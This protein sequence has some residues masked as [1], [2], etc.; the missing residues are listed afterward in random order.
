MGPRSTIE[1]IRNPSLIMRVAL[2]LLV[3]MISVGM[4]MAA[5][6]QTLRG[7][8]FTTSTNDHTVEWNENWNA[9][10]EGDDDFSTMVMLEGQIMIYAVMFIHD[11]LA[12]LSPKSV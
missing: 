10:L 12:G 2:I 6:A 1:A 3:M 4:P 8:S 5:S 11:P 9:S 7:T